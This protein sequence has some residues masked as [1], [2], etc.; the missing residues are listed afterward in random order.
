MSKKL[1]D[2]LKI[3]ITTHDKGRSIQL[4]Y[5]TVRRC[6]S[7]GVSNI[8]GFMRMRGAQK[9]SEEEILGVSQNN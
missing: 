6:N 3:T 1:L 9:R 5:T 2:V 8:L 4:P 7:Q